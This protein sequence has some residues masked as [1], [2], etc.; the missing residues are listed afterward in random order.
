[1]SAVIHARQVVPT[2]RPV[3]LDLYTGLLHLLQE[4]VV[5]LCPSD[6]VE[7]DMNPHPCSCTIGQSRC[8]FLPDL[9]GPIDVGFESHRLPCRTN[10][11]EHGWK[12]LISVQES[13]DPVAIE[14]GRP[15]QGAYRADELGISDRVEV[16]DSPSD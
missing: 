13:L 16:F 11:P 8:E 1:M 14:D 2:K 7:E 12:D 9:T 6:P 5:D 10:R 4:R 3:L 15:E